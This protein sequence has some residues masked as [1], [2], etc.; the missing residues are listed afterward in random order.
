VSHCPKTLYTIF[1]DIPAQRHC[2]LWQLC[3]KQGEE[4]RRP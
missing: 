2:I 1:N 4:R 3:E